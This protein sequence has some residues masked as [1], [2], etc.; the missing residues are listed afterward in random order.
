[1]ILQNFDRDDF[2][3]NY[4]QKKPLLMRGAFPDWQN[5]LEPDE[6]AGLACEDDIESRLIISSD[7]YEMKHGPFDGEQFAA[8]EDKIYTLL[9]QA[10]DHHIPEVSVILDAFRF[11]PNWR[12]DDVMV[13]YANT[14]GGVGAHYDQ[15]DVFLLQG[16]GQRRWQIGQ[17]CDGNTALLPHDDLRLMADFQVKDEWILD[18]GDI[19]YVPP[20]LAHNGIAQ[21]DDCMTYSIGFRTPSQYELISHYSDYILDEICEDARYQDK[22]FRGQDN[23]GEISDKAIDRLHKMML[24]K[25]SNKAGFTRWLGQYL[26]APKYGEPHPSDLMDHDMQ[27]GDAIIRNPASRF[28]YI[29]DGQSLYVDGIYY[30]CTGETANFA[31]ALCSYEALIY[32]YNMSDDIKLLIQKLYTQ[33]AICSS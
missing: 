4:W 32:Q 17:M 16:L 33:N 2:L 1:M 25:I 9:V 15:Y 26:S 20:M 6:L 7:D 24:S 22:S 18:T 21:S 8:L 3:E 23:S 12:I 28:V 19:L 27:N 14:G 31:K 29:D 10:V 13:S 11:I 5:P 30:D